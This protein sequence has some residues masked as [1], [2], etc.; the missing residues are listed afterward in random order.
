VVRIQFMSRINIRVWL[1]VTDCDLKWICEGG[2]C[3]GGLLDSF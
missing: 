2:L 3:Q 1:S